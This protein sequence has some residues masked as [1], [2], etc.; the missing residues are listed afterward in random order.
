MQSRSK[1]RSLKLDRVALENPNAKALPS[2][3]AD[4]NRQLTKVKRERTL[5][6]VK[7]EAKEQNEL[8]ERSATEIARELEKAVL[9]GCC[10]RLARG[11]EANDVLYRRF[12]VQTAEA[13]S[14]FFARKALTFA[15]VTLALEKLAPRDT[16]EAM[17]SVQIVGVHAQAMNYMRLA[18]H[19]DQTSAGEELYVNLATRLMRTFAALTEALTRH[20]RKGGQKMRIEHVHVY[21]GGQAIVGQVNPKT[22]IRSKGKNKDGLGWLRNGNPPGNPNLAERCGAKTRR[23]RKCQSPAMSNG[24]CR[25]H[26]GA[27]T[28]PRT[29]AG[30]ARSRRANW[31]HG[32]Y[33]AEAKAS[34]REVR[35][36]LRTCKDLIHRV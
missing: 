1:G 35:K 14:D 15:E 36:L 6:R 32:N 2:P 27:S 26:G 9:E 19:R 4:K 33:S 24:R 3:Q 22:V 18:A 16:L 25:M 23:G 31:K 34:I 11:D 12:I 5:T 30:L 7:P 28:G 17:L 13:N 20:R 21:Q 8:R 10:S 29:P